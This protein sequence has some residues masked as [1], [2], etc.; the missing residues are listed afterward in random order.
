MSRNII[1]ASGDIARFSFRKVEKS[2]QRSG[3]SKG[4]AREIA[5]EVERQLKPG[6]RTSDIY[7]KAFAL[8]KEH[9]PHIAAR[10]SLK[11]AILALGPS[12]FPF[13]TFIGALLQHKGYSVSVGQKV[14]GH[15]VMHEVDVV[16]LKDN[17]HYFV[18]CKFHNEQK[19]QTNVKVPLYIYARFLDIQKQLHKTGDTQH[20]HRQLIVTNT[21]FTKDAEQYSRC[22][23]IDLLGWRYPND[24]GLEHLIE[25]SGLHP[26]TSLTTLSK[27]DKRV[28]LDRGMVL[29]KEITHVKDLPKI[30]NMSDA[31][32]N[33]VMKEVQA[34]CGVVPVASQ[35][36]L[37]H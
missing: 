17:R 23:N 7:Q 37:V 28:L 36:V 30:L 22:M 10:Y 27:H 6:M 35:T 1:K 5:K 4:L 14:Q 18:E 3:A 25:E 16:A 29:C 8:L 20:E 33:A 24:Q 32:G 19:Y 15:C 11:H 13:E 9:E 31:K 26:I 2:L 12:G 34:L 21:R